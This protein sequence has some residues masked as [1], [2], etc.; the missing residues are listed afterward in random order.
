MT[1]PI[2]DWATACRSGPAHAGGK[3]WQ[4]AALA[5]MGISVPP[6][7][8]INASA[9]ANRQLGDPLSADL[10]TALLRELETRSWS[11]LPLAVRSSA[12][13]EDSVRASFA[14]IYRSCLNVRG[15]EATLRAV[16][17]VVDSLWAPAAVAYRE[18]LGITN[19]DATMAVVVMPLLPAVAS[20]IVFTCDPISGREDQ[21]VIHA[22]WGLGEAL[23]SGHAEGDEYRL[24][25]DDADNSLTLIDQ[26]QGSK[27]RMTVTTMH[28]GTEL[29]NTP[30]DLVIRS[31]LSA[32]QAV[33]LGKLVRDAAT[34]LD[35]ANPRYDVE[36]VW[37]G[38]SFWIVQA[39]PITVRGRYTYPGLANQ[40]TL[41]SRG[42]SRDVVPDPLS[43]LDWSLSLLDR[44][45]IQSYIL[46]GY[47]TLPGVRR[48]TLRYGRLYFE[49]SI[50]QWE[51]FDAFD[52]P[53]RS[54]NKMMGGHQPEISVPKATLADRLARLRRSLRYIRRCVKPRRRA[55]VT[56]H[57]ARR[58]A[59]EWLAKKI[60]TDDA[61]LARQLREQIAVIR[62]ADDLFF[63]QASSGSAILVLSDLVEKYCPEEGQALTAALLAGGEPSVT[64]T[65]G[66]EL[67][68]LARIA[69]DDPAAFA[70]L[71][72]PDRNGADWSRKLAEDNPFRRAF[73]EFIQRYGHRGVYETYLRNARWREAPDYL[74]NSIVNLI[75]CDPDELRERQKRIS[76]PAR[77]RVAEALP[78]WYRP[79]IPLLVKFATVERNLREAGRSALMAYLEIV[80]CGTLGLGVRSTGLSGL[81]H[82][83]EIFNL[84]LP[85]VLALAEGNLP[86]ACAAKRAAWRRRQLEDAALQVEPEV[87]IEHGVAIPPTAPV[88]T[89]AEKAQDTVWQGSVVSSGQ[90]RGIACIA[91]HPTEALNMQTGAILVTPSTDPSWT[92]LFLRAGALVMETGGFLSHGAIVAR[93]FGIPA[94]VNLPGIL[95]QIRNGDNLEVDGN[96]GTVRRL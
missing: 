1:T 25:E 82:P 12:C 40:P 19:Q 50:I 79:L 64:A 33:A 89:R 55:K 39:R 3:G 41:W 93:E 13:M 68:E 20:G 95:N 32:E 73:A 6:G 37:D 30:A 66:Y 61:A 45:L 15:V 27:A 53:P 28:G 34:A 92:P 59:A 75:G 48:T 18:R 80:R 65:Q 96:R 62:R 58:Q 94:V 57:R 85:E 69:A 47:E 42:N 56:L 86:V 88:A 23:V 81:E 78:F 76:D 74:L 26:R 10:M 24:Q 52:V 71:R 77:R 29:S 63:L 70:W 7:F 2:L 11:D 5:E 31:V 51:A 36:W 38:K 84:T 83:E 14:G 4:L 60:P 35:Y 91:R 17:D 46:S 49:T 9:T 90:A 72:C 43:P 67:M 22:H 8:V 21:I 87:I 16:E 44:M 54:F